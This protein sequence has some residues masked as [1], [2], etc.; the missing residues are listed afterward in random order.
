MR[1]LSSSSS[2]TTTTMK[3]GFMMAK[4]IFKSG[5]VFSL[6]NFFAILLIVINLWTR[7]VSSEIETVVGVEAVT[8][9][10]TVNVSAGQNITSFLAFDSWLNDTESGFDDIINKC[11]DKCAKEDQFYGNLQA[12]GCR[13]YN[14][15][16]TEG[17]NKWKQS[18]FSTCKQVCRDDTFHNNLSPCDLACISGCNQAIYGIVEHLSKLDDFNNTRPVLVNDD[19][20]TINGTSLKLSWPVDERKYSTKRLVIQWAYD[21]EYPLRWKFSSNFQWFENYTCEI[22]KLQPYTKYRFRI[23]MMVT[24]D[25]SDFIYSTESEVFETLPMG[26]PSSKPEITDILTLDYDK[27]AIFWK[28]GRYTNG[29]LEGYNLTARIANMDSN[30]TIEVIS[31]ATD[32]YTILH[33]LESDQ[34]YDIEL[35]MQ[36]EFGTGPS[37]LASISTGKLPKQSPSPSFIVV[38]EFKVTLLNTSSDSSTA[39]EIYDSDQMIVGYD[40][41][42]DQRIF[43]VSDISGHV[44]RIDM[45]NS[46]ARDAIFSPQSFGDFKPSKIS[47]EQKSVNSNLYILGEPRNEG[48]K[49]IWVIFQ[50]SSNGDDLRPIVE[51]LSEKPLELHVDPLNGFLFWITQESGIYRYELAAGSWSIIFKAENL[52]AFSIEPTKYLLTAFFKNDKQFQRIS[53]DGK[54]AFEA[55]IDVSTEIVLDL[56]DYGSK[57]YW[58]DGNQIYNNDSIT[59][60]FESCRFLKLFHPSDQESSSVNGPPIEFQALL[61]ADKAKLSWKPPRKPYFQS[62]SLL[63]AYQY[64][65]EVKEDEV[66]VAIRNIKSEFFTVEKLKPSTEYWFRVRANLVN[67]GNVN[68]GPWSEW[69]KSKTWMPSE[70]RHLL[71]A[72]VNGLLR[73]DEVGDDVKLLMNGSITS[74]TWANGTLFVVKNSHLYNWDM[75]NL[76]GFEVDNSAGNVAFDWKGNQL[77]LTDTSKGLVVRSHVDGTSRELLPILDAK[78]IELDSENGYIYFSTGLRIKAC[79]LNGKAC[80]TYYRTSLFSEEELIGPALDLKNGRVLWTIQSD[81][82]GYL[83]SSAL[84]HIPKTAESPLMIPLD[85]FPVKNWLSYLSAE[86]LIWPTSSNS[87]IMTN[88]SGGN[89]A[90]IHFEETLN[91]VYV[92]EPKLRLQASYDIIPDEVNNSTVKII[93]LWDDFNITW[94]PVFIDSVYFNVSYSIQIGDN[95]F[96]DSSEPSVHYPRT[97]LLPYSPLRVWIRS[98]SPW[99]SSPVTVVDVFSPTAAPSEPQRLRV[100]INR[101]ANPSRG[102]QNISAIVRWESPEEPNGPIIQYTTV[103]K[104]GEEYIDS[105]NSTGL[106]AIFW[107]LE[108]NSTYSFQVQAFTSGAGGQLTKSVEITVNSEYQSIPKLLTAGDGLI[109][110]LDI[111]LNS[112]KILAK[113]EGA[114]QHLTMIN[115]EKNYVVW[116]DDAAQM[117]SYYKG[118]VS[119][120]THLD[121]TAQSLTIDWVSR[122]VYWSQS[123]HG[124]GSTIHSLDLNRFE[125]EALQG[126]LVIS[127]PKP[128]KNL[129]MF[130]LSQTLLWLEL[131]GNLSGWNFMNSTEIKLFSGSN[132][133]YKTLYRGSFE[134][135]QESVI[136][137]DEYDDICIL[138]IQEDTCQALKIGIDSNNLYIAQDNGYF[139]VLKNHSIR[140]YNRSSPESLEYMVHTDRIDMITALNFQPYPERRCLLPDFDEEPL[141]ETNLLVPQLINST[142]FSFELKFPKISTPSECGIE[143]PGLKYTLFLTEAENENTDA[144]ILHVFEPQM[145]VTELKPFTRYNLQLHISNYYSEKFEL[146]G[147]AG[148]NVTIGT[149]PGTPWAPDNMTASAVSPRD[150]L[151]EWMEPKILNNERVWYEVHWQTENPTSGVVHRHQKI[152][153]ETD[154][155]WNSFLLSGLK[156][157]H[158]Y[159][160]WIVVFSTSTLFNESSIYTF[161]TF[162]EPEGLIFLNSTS[163]TLT[164]NWNASVN[165]TSAFL[166][167]SP[168]NIDDYI[169]VNITGDSQKRLIESLEPK[170]KYT[171][172]M[173]LFYANSVH[174]YVWPPDNR[175]VFE[176][177]GDRPGA[178]GQPLIEHIKGEVFKIFWEPARNNGAPILEYSLEAL[179]SSQVKRVRRSH[180]FPQNDDR[181]VNNKTLARL[182]QLPWAEEIQ[183][184]Q[185]KWIPYCNGTDTNCIIKELHT[186]RLLMFRGRARNSFGWG[187][188][189]ADSEMIAEP[190]VSPRKRDTL[191]FAIVAPITIVS[192]CVSMAFLIKYVHGRRKH[193]KKLVDDLKPSI[194]GLD[195]ATVQ[196]VARSRNFS[197]TS[198][199]LYTGKPL[200]DGDIALLPQ[201][202]RNQINMQ[203]FL[204]SG[205]FG[206]VYEGLVT[207]SSD[208]SQDRVAIKTLRK[209]ANDQEKTELLQEAHLMSHFKHENIVKLIGV[210]FD[211]E[212]MCI[213]MELME[214]GDL[215]TYLRES[216]PSMGKPGTL[217]L[218]ELVGMCLDVC[219]GCRYLEDLQFLHRDL[220]CRNCLVSS[221]DPQYRVV[222]IGDFGLARDIYKCDYYR[223]EGEGLLPVRWMAPECLVDGVF[224]SQSDIWSFGI[225]LWEILSLGQQPYP[226]QSNLEVLN[227]VKEGGRLEKPQDCPEKLYNLMIECWSHDPQDRPTFQKCLTELM[228]VKV[229]ALNKLH[230]KAYDGGITNMSYTESES[231]GESISKAYLSNISDKQSSLNESFNEK[232]NQRNQSDESP[233]ELTSFKVSMP[234]DADV[235]IN[236]PKLKSVHYVNEG[237]SRF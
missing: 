108:N 72:T 200:T 87:V 11:L 206:E 167:Y 171:F 175:F 62:Q 94:Q 159:T 177:L 197:Q 126:K 199:M 124:G 234:T 83:F 17:C 131:D 103:C 224:T 156:P 183:P 162:P 149:A 47:V 164:L 202:S 201:I 44:F 168:L 73:S 181:Q 211:L 192:T 104:R 204:G 48:S 213:I 172:Q 85:R 84:A 24:T 102:A 63:I 22:E 78:H 100:F 71:W 42:V 229:E 225:L 173:K 21:N 123:D 40:V 235:N 138:D 9:A 10:S 113:S 221:V 18:T 112:T 96:L 49:K 111:D 106:E 110:L 191:V 56:V 7:T 81:H 77:Y 70:E 35:S 139:F 69:F 215:Q 186:M 46:V 80:M 148:P 169:S 141:V 89:E 95:V 136:L 43:F 147:V 216:R 61:T 125:G 14:E 8:A 222:K 27:I 76:T 107:D 230:T 65:L 207:Y 58:T 166:L 60:L 1:C 86:R 97:D 23:A 53:Y 203:R 114:I 151:V 232:S 152:I 161:D 68:N 220:A 117:M 179:Q 99:K 98:N 15:L 88:A 178:P 127:N 121:S 54:F 132:N 20:D 3:I 55:D 29:K 157:D 210:C 227:F 223:K 153:P 134:E 52:T 66:S 160:V 38:G 237:L 135:N 39:T 116:I 170:T 158:S 228:S 82:D 90:R 176:T 195:I 6:S 205:A 32:N 154:D 190:F 231:D 19:N 150:G 51:D 59:V 198:S 133:T 50:S 122:L 187:P 28:Q 194:W 226:A 142:T 212:S 30:S 34:T 180:Y 118:N 12:V 233:R 5:S 115:E 120:L 57:I 184:I 2:T 67:P 13:S 165:V 140:A 208:G 143:V 163:S 128:I 130:P 188:Y 182:G 196:Q 25:H 129:V 92:V 214:G 193:A 109:E 33:H 144:K 37:T 236:Q 74:V 75:T 189:S 145:N 185:D 219:T 119:I 209:G 4:P 64:D 155:K 217:T 101:V 26:V 79:R 36:N 105:V 31:T 16:C 41:I 174:S 45:R 91:G 218:L 93:G 146:P 137:V